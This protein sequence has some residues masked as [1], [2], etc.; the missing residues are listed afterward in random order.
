ME[1]GRFF[2]W[3]MSGDDRSPWTQRTLL[4]QAL[5]HLD[6]A[7]GAVI[8]PIHVT[9]TYARNE[10]YSYPSTNSYGRPDNPTV[11]EAQA[12]CAM[13]EGGADACLFGSGMSAAI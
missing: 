4:A 10:D 11:H 7:T 13:L 1:A 6:A 8:Q 3:C 2:G 9:T 12:I 5:G